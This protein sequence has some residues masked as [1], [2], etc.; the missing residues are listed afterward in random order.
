MIIGPIDPN[1]YWKPFTPTKVGHI[2]PI[3]EFGSRIGQPATASGRFTSRVQGATWRSK[4]IQLAPGMLIVWERAAYRV[5][6]IDERPDDLWPERFETA[7]D[8]HHAQ[9]LRNLVAENAAGPEPQRSTWSGRPVVLALTNPACP[10]N[11]PLHVVGPAHHRW[12]VLPEHYAVCVDCGDLA[13]CRHEVADK[14]AD[15]ETATARVRMTFPADAC[16]GCGEA[17][18]GR[19]KAIAFPGPNLWRPDLPGHARFHARQDCAGF[20]ESYRTAWLASGG[21]QLQ[22]T[23]PALDDET[24]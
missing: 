22:R 18:A 2:D 23:Q 20:V 21:E 12:E 16:M 8:E 5:T 13:P 9:W 3:G 1:G 11:Q 17:I 6:S 7:W 19:Q 4:H 15:R 14:Q 24:P 10:K